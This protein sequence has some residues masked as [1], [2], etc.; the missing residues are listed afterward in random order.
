MYLG[1]EEFL[2]IVRR[3]PLVSIDLIV[4][5]EG[6]NVLVGWRK[7]RPAKDRWFVPGGRIRKDERIADAFRRIT[8]KELGVEIKVEDATFLGVFEH[9][10]EDNYGGLPG[11]GTHYIVHAYEISLSARDVTPPTEQHSQY[12]WLSEREALENQDVHDHT[13]A[14]CSIKVPQRFLTKFD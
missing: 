11:F 14:Y 13:R 7:N 4:R 5:D 10:Y 8:Q 12:C 3:T 1:Q 9:L 2:E 6:G